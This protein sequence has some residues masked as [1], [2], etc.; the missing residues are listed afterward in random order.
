MRG[1]EGY[2]QKRALVGTYS[3]YKQMQGLNKVQS[4]VSRDHRVPTVQQ[5]EMILTGQ[6]Q[7]LSRKPSRM[8]GKGTVK[9]SNSK[10]NNELSQSLNRGC[11][12]EIQL[13]FVSLLP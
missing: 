2:T 11:L 8:P 3:S 5:L 10:T 12:K 13:V 7:F 4:S 1:K 9:D 6:Q